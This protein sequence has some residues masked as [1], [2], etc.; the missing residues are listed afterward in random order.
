[1]VIVEGDFALFRKG[2]QALQR[3]SCADLHEGKN[4]KV[5]EEEGD[6]GY[7]VFRVSSESKVRLLASP[8][9]ATGGACLG[10]D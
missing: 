4:E 8:P 5:S 2:V 10:S 3:G 1:M 9:A 6:H 7:R